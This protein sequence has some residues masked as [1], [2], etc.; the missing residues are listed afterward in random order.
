MN[1]VDWFVQDFN[2]ESNFCGESRFGATLRGNTPNCRCSIN[3]IFEELDRKLKGFDMPTIK[4]VIFNNPATIIYWND[5]SKTVVKCQNGEYFD[6]EK[7]FALAYLKKLLGNDN[8]FNKEIH[9]W[10]ECGIKKKK[11]SNLEKFN[12]G[13]RIFAE[14][15]IGCHPGGAW[16]TVVEVLDKRFHTED[17]RVEFDD[18]HNRLCSHVVPVTTTPES[19]KYY[20]GKVNG[21]TIPHKKKIKSFEEWCEFSGSKWIELL[22]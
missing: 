10:V 2:V 14:D 19:I 16:G 8:T 22:E 7:G 3:D 9:K 5:G 6:K 18:T 13:D 11:M 1:I 4:K 17:Y 21:N 12:V 20:N 15:N